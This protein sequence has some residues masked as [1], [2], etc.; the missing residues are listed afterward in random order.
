MTQFGIGQPV[1]RVEDRRFITGRGRYLD[2]IVRP[3][4][5]HAV[6]LRSP[7]AHAVIRA[8]DTSAAREAPGVAMVLTGADLAADGLGTVP[9]VSGVAGA[10]LPP[11]PAMVEGRVRH[12]GDTVAMVIAESVAAARD[13]ADLIVVDYEPLPA[14]VDTAHATD[15]GQPQVW[16][17]A[18][19][20][21]SFAW[22]VGDGAAVGRAAA[23]AKHKVTL[24][25]VNN[26]V[27]VTSMEPRGAI[28]EHDPGEDA[29]TLWSSTQGS[30]FVRN[31]LAEHVLHIPENRIRVVTP[32]VGG[33]FGMKLFLYPE[34]VLVLWAAKRVGRA[35]KWVPDRADSFMTDTQ[36]RDNVTKLDLSLDAD[37]KFL[38]LSVEL[39]ANMG[40]YLSNFAPEIPTFSGAV[41]HSGVY[42]IP[43][44]HVA[45]K[46][47]FTHTVP[48]DAYRGAGRPEAAY[49][50]E[51]LIEFA[52]R[53][54]GVAPAE[55]RRRNLVPAAAMP[56]ATPLGLT[57]DSGDF[58]RNLDQALQSVDL[59]GF[60]ARRAAAE[61]RGHYRGLG[62]AVYIEQ[63]GF[64]PD[65]F[66]EARFDPSG[67]LT[68]LMGSQSSGQGHQTAYAQLASEKL[69]LALEKIRVVQGDSAAIGFGRGTG[70]SRSI[71]VGGGA[72]MH[73]ADKLI[74]KGKRIAAHLL[75][76]AEADIS[77]AVD[78]AD[79]GTFAIAGTDRAVT[80][81]AVARA[82][83][84]PAQLPPD[85]EPGFAESGHFTPPAPTFPN[86]VHVCE[87]E[88]DPDT[89]VVKIE[90]YLVVDDFG[91][92]INPLLLAGQVN[93]GIA[94]GV[95]QAMLE[96]TVFDPESGQL[97]SGTLQDYA[98][99]R[100]DDL[101]AL[102][103]AYNIVPCRTNP[104]GV[105]GA[106]EA[107]AI[108]SP[109]ALINAIV[110][111]LGSL[112]IDHLD[113][114]ATPE[115]VWRAIR[116]AMAKAA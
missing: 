25:I 82:A 76:A 77:F 18:Q 36:G 94:Q 65:E 100:A 96:H 92:V 54:L 56:Y 53:K 106:G 21:L 83:F 49:A 16:D 64:P 8:I 90:R 114:P 66:A 97:L 84:N 40:A 14:A 69:G 24:T 68:L 22:E 87:I 88:I 51:R 26:R 59:A 6:F 72:L 99:P 42:A 78:D 48:V 115:V 17:E 50:L 98:L 101:P 31:L 7:H 60:A 110:D 37:L 38:G 107:G 13:A 61:A 79:G 1:R 45:V 19:N 108:G 2:D 105:K 15:P 12:V 9:C 43:A 20:N 80:L 27:V 41:M 32:D 3:R 44:I 55:L 102:E 67:T 70:G 28:G 39:V 73:A 91:V 35:V 46:G 103:F 116:A 85:V 5:A 111:A 71:P 4:Q 74:A 112:G 52:A 104:L 58:A 95:G 86:G 113:M 93:G 29:Y 75:E 11:R 63:S 109:P 33:G 23:G 57:Y 62:Q 89:G 30:H 34:H 47:V 10:V 81:D